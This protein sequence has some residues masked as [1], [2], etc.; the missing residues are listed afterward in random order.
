MPT[1]EGRRMTYIDRYAHALSAQYRVA[2]FREDIQNE[3]D[4]VQYYDSLIGQ[5]RQTLAGLQEIFRAEDVNF[6]D[7]RKL[8]EQ[9][10]A[11]TT[12]VERTKAG[13]AARARSATQLPRSL[14]GAV[15]LPPCYLPGAV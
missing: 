14:V 12:G 10:D 3:Q 6:S 4:R 2:Q 11:A 15:S 8:I 1:P 9:V 5:E 7:A 13:A